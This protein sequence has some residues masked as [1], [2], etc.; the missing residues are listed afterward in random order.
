M[1][2][3]VSATS[4][5][6]VILFCGLLIACGGGVTT[7]VV[8]N[9]VPASV[10]LNSPNNLSLELGKTRAFSASAQNALGTTIAETFEYES[11]APGI[12]TIAANGNA[13]AGTWDSLTAPTLCTP[14]STGIAQVTAIANGVSSP[15]VSVYVHQRVTRVVIQKVPNQPPSFS[16]S[17]Y[18]RGIPVGPESVLYE[19]FAYSGSSGTNDI[20][21]TV[22]PFTWGTVSVANQSSGSAAVLLGSAGPTA[23]LNQETA[24]A[25]TPGMSSIFSSAGGVTSQP[26]PFVTCPVQSIVLSINGA[27]VSA[28]PILLGSAQGSVTVNA[29]ATDSVGLTLT[30]VPLTWSSSDPESVSVSGNTSSVYT[31]TGSVGVVTSGGAAITASCTPPACNGGI[32]PSL[33]VYPDQAASF[34]TRTSQA[35]TTSAFFATTTAC[36]QTSQSCTPRIVPITRTGSS[37]PFAAGT[38]TSLPSSPNSFS[39]GPVTGAVGY[40]GV[41]NSG[42]GS[43]GLMAFNGSAATSVAGTVGQVMGISPDGNTVVLSDTTDSPSRIIICRSCASARNI[44]QLPFPSVSAVAFSP[45][46]SVG[47]SS[48]FKIYAVSAGSCPGTSS[49]G[50]LLVVSTVDAPKTVPLLSPATG[51]AFI[52][53]GA[54]GYI[55][56][57]DP[58]GV[59]Y[60]PTCDV[61]PSS[62][63]LLPTV[64]AASLLLRTMP[65]GQSV[66]SL[67]PP[68]LQT[69]TTTLA[70][71]GCPAPR[72]NLTIA[73]TVG[74]TFN[75]GQG[76]FNPKQFILSPDGST[77]YIVAQTTGGASLPYIITA[78]LTTQTSSLISLAGNATPLTA[79]LSHA[80]DLLFV[81]ATD[82]Q[83]HVIDTTSGVDTQQVAFAF[84]QTS[85]CIGPGAPATQPAVSSVTISAAALS[86]TSTTYTYSLVN[87]SPLQVGVSITITAMNDAGNNG[88]FTITALGQNTFTVVNGSGVTVSG[89]NGSGIV[90]LTCNPDLIAVKP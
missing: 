6:L 11:S 15:P 58:A 14:G 61:P 41:Q 74:P 22:G 10:S 33:A 36:S 78:N 70:G 80:G 4:A 32:Y 19:A 83:V 1:D 47:G 21:A 60:L 65:D 42:L 57:G 39:F 67:A 37:A 44:T 68:N 81:G 85:L 84:P 38:P 79:A 13:C 29:T 12:L 53:D 63:G 46:G 20:T 88:T 34:I 87:G 69:I 90:P 3:F 89:Q 55:A 31:S 59:T 48:G 72:G 50:C 75:L 64:S 30:G 86:G 18:T 26:L 43:Q 77:V 56:G 62:A 23:P 54:V 40:L 8:K 17:C 27:P 49:S 45:E 24:F 73:P 16:N 5:A 66:L 76:V 52:G 82:G 35:P 51:A 28:T 25:N 71:S 2:R 7:Q 9:G